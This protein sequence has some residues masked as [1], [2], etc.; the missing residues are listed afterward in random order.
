MTAYLGVARA[1]LQARAAAAERYP[2]APL[3]ASSRDAQGELGRTGERTG[4]PE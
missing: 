1:R 4:A 3:Q 2:R